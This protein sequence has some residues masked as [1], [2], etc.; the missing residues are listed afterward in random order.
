MSTANSFPIVTPTSHQRSYT[1]SC[2]YSQTLFGNFNP[3]G[4]YVKCRGGEY[5]IDKINIGHELPDCVR[6]LSYFY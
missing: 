6:K 1:V 5:Y 3:Y 2:G 4:E